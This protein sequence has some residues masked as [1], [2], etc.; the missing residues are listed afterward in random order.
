MQTG[1]VQA[2]E[3]ID[4]V[5]KATGSLQTRAGLLLFVATLRLALGPTQPLFNENG[6][7]FL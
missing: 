5:W 3:C 2:A 7:P 1:I 4:A 6:G